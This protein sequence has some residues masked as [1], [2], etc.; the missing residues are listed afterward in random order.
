VSKTLWAAGAAIALAGGGMITYGLTST[1]DTHQAPVPAHTYEAADTEPAGYQFPDV[2]KVDGPRVVIPAI[3]VEVR[4]M[5]AAMSDGILAVPQAPHAGWY[6]GSRPPGSQQGATVIAG[7]VDYPTRE[8]TP[9]G[10]IHK[11]P[12]GSEIYVVDEDGTR[13]TY[14]ATA[15]RLFEQDTLPPELFVSTGDPVLHLV[16]CAGDSVGEGG[17]WN[18]EYNLV[19]TAELVSSEPTT[20]AR[21]GLGR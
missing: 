14:V 6:E 21:P 12:Q 4:L 3:D 13:H 8:L 16:T 18:Y 7:H 19:V 17:Q 10:R 5:D 20:E 9:F 2:A 1:G 11:L 15:L